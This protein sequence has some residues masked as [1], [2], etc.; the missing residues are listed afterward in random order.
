MA[1]GTGTRIDAD[2]AVLEDVSE[3]L[4]LRWSD[5]AQ[6]IRVDE[7]TVHRWKKGD[8]APQPGARSRIAQF[9]ELLELLAR[10]F[11]GP[12]LARRWLKEKRP[13]A[14][15]GNVTPLEVMLAGRLD[16][17]VGLLHFLGRGG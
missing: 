14:L 12:D 1:T 6:I 3:K 5:I 15:G 13:Q 17:V 4:K 2:V 16:R 9:R 11:D 10:T 7:S 8:V